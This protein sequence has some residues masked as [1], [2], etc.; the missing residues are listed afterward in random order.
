MTSATRPV[1][2][3]DAARR[4]DD[5][6]APRAAVGAGR[7]RRLARCRARAGRSRRSAVARSSGRSRARTPI[8]SAHG[9]PRRRRPGPSF[10]VPRDFISLAKAA[11]CHRDPERFAL[12]YAIA[13]EAARQSQ[14]A[15]RSRRSAGRPAREIGQGGAPRRAQDARLRPLPRDRGARRRHA[16]R[17]LVRARQPYRPARSRL[18]RP[19][20]RQHALVDPDARAVDPLGRRDAARRA[21]RDRGR[22]A[23]RRSGRGDVEDLLRQHLQPGAGQGEGD[24][25]GNAQ[26][27]LGEHARNRAGRAA[28]RR[29]A[30]TRG[31]DD[32]TSERRSRMP[33]RACA[34]AV[35]HAAGGNLRGV[36]RRC[37]TRPLACTRCDLY[38]CA[39][40]TVFGEGPLD[41][42]ILFVGEQP[43]D[44]E[45]LAGRPFV[46]PAG[47]V[48]NAALEE[49]GIDR[50][51]DLRHQRGQAFQIRA[52]RQAANP[53]DA[54]ARTRS[55]PAAGGSSRN[56]S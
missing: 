46:G 6:R 1:R 55:A 37:A 21:G 35:P 52:A 16:L 9:A 54:R 7:F 53:P 31:G 48:F 11:I 22:C 30:G 3:G 56:A 10:A 20:L 50:A 19:P 28:D 13:A 44:Q 40:Q 14:G 2:S 49:A 25:E 17:R 47:E 5:R 38:K 51:A 4:A 12:L 8:C 32:R 36:G 42:R 43:G 26:E 15:R 23:R 18:L 29:R 27:I 45:D 33:M 39:T 34:D 41:A 24:A